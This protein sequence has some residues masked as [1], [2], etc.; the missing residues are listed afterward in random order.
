MSTIVECFV[1]TGAFTLGRVLQGIEYTFA[2]LEG[3]VATGSGANHDRLTTFVWV[4]NPETPAIATRLEHADAVRSSR[5]LDEFDDRALFRVEWISEADGWVQRLVEL[6]V[7]LLQASG[8]AERWRFQLRFHTEEA[9]S[10]FQAIRHEQEFSIDV[11][12]V[13]DLEQWETEHPADAMG[14][15][16]AQ[17]EALATAAAEGYFSVPRETNL[18]DLSDQLD[19]SGQSLSERLRRGEAKLLAATLGTTPKSRPNPESECE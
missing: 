19:I 17:H 11:Q 12:R 10:A 3:V 9:L 7:A 8:T 1:P 16:P 4:T 15:T 5:L 6:D 13:V 18:V 2:E 14:L